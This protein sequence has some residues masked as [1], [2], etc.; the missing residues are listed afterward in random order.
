MSFVHVKRKSKVNRIRYYYYIPTAAKLPLWL[1]L[2]Y[3]GGVGAPFGWWSK[4]S[5]GLDVYKSYSRNRWPFF[6]EFDGKSDSEVDI[7]SPEELVDEYYEAAHIQDDR[8]QYPSPG[9]TVPPGYWKRYFDYSPYSFD[10]SFP[11]DPPLSG[12]SFPYEKEDPPGFWDLCIPY[13]NWVYDGDLFTSGGIC[14][15]V[16]TYLYRYVTS[17]E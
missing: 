10:L 15:I 17:G 9:Q 16:G 11:I 6:N 12:F 14:N 13:T 1:S 7:E 4:T 5:G 3:Y 8:P 2:V